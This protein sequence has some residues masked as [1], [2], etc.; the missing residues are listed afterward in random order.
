[1]MKDNSILFDR[2]KKT[3]QNV[4]PSAD[5]ILY[6]SYARGE[7]K[8][9]SDIDLLILVSNNNLSYEDRKKISYPLFNIEAEVGISISPLIYD[10]GTWENKH[11]VTPFYKNIKEDGIL[12]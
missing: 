9:E 2:I 1:M 11:Y 3:V 12:L 10:K 8:E 7:Q 4:E 5:I 6:G